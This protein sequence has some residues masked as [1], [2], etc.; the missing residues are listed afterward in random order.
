VASD[1]FYGHSVEDALAQATGRAPVLDVKQSAI[2]QRLL[3]E[4][5]RALRDGEDINVRLR[6]VNRR[7]SSLK[8]RRFLRG[9][10][11]FTGLVSAIGGIV[12]RWRLVLVAINRLAKEGAPL[13]VGYKAV[14]EA[15]DRLISELVFFRENHREIGRVLN[16]LQL[17]RREIGQLGRR[18]EGL[19]HDL[20]A[21]NC[22]VGGRP[23]R[24][25]FRGR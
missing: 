24:N 13:F 14:E 21:N 1:E 18:I 10:S 15:I 22:R 9:A 8:E 23:T 16:D 6:G 5:E 2:C 11:N 19:R 17:I 7:L 20:S 25:I 3:N 12:A 4:A